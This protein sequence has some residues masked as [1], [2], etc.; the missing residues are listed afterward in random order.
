MS[1]T[2]RRSVLLAAAAATL[3][4]ACGDDES[5]S[6]STVSTNSGGGSECAP[7]DGSAAQQRTF[8]EG[9]QMCLVDGA[10][11]R[12]TIETNHGSFDVALR[13]DIAPN[14]VN[15]F[16]NLARYHYFDGTTCHRAIQNFVVQCGDPT[17]TGTGD[18]GYEFDDELDRI[19]PYRIGSL[20]M[21]NSGPNTQGSQ[22]FIITGDDGAMLPPNYTLFGQ[23]DD[24]DLGM[25]ATLDSFANPADGP[26]LQ[27]I[28]IIS[29]TI[30]EG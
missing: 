23:V 27:P 9:P 22:F 14:T 16:V 12:A 3:F 10:T 29:I 28:D 17:A 30:T 25:V 26:P 15:S 6:D 19:E 11:Y 20:A 8:E 18:P 2:F 4:A 1:R 24:D 5:T 7:A 13:P 21:A